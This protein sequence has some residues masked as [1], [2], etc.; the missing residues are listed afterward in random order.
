MWCLVSEDENTARYERRCSEDAEGILEINADG[1]GDG[2]SGCKLIARFP[3]RP[4]R[5]KFECAEPRPARIL[6][7]QFM[8][9][10][11]YLTTVSPKKETKR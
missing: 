5:A 11:R 6:D 2:D 4:Y 9:R 8:R 1:L 10:G 7:M 3:G